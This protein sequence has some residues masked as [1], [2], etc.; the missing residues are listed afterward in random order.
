MRSKRCWKSEAAVQQSSAKAKMMFCKFHKFHEKVPAMESL[1]R[2][3]LSPHACDC[4]SKV[5][6]TG[7]FS[8]CHFNSGLMLFQDF[9]CLKTDQW[10][11]LPHTM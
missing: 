10:K 4:T 9:F 8:F 7:S 11:I 2:D 5:A 1:L 3:N 6:I